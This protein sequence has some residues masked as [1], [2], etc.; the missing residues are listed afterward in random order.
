MADLGG[1]SE[2]GTFAKNLK[3]RLLVTVDI[4]S[5]VLPGGGGRVS[6]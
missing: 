5:A 4:R 3:E 6:G 2:T 1:G